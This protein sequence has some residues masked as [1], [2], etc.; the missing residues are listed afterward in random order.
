MIG[1]RKLPAAPAL[2]IHICQCYAQ[3]EQVGEGLGFERD[4]V[5]VHHI[6][7]SAQL[8]HAFLYGLLQ[9]LDSPHIHVP[10]TYYCGSSPDCGDVFGHLLGFLDVAADDTGVCAKVHKGSDLGRADCARAT[11]AKHHFVICRID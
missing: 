11:S 2:E 3:E 1:A 6:I 5:I 9:T 10:D 7:D 4:K 8:L